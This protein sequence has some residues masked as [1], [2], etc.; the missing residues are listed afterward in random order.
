LLIDTFND[1][2]HVI[3]SLN[4]KGTLLIKKEEGE[5]VPVRKILTQVGLGTIFS[6]IVRENPTIRHK[7]GEHAFR[8]IIN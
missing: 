5:K 3:M 1:H 6:D 2:P 4:A 7:V 8:Y